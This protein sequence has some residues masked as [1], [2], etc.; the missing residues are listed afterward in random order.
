[1]IAAPSLPQRSNNRHFTQQLQ[2][3]VVI[4]VPTYCKERCNAVCELKS[5]V[6][7]KG[8]VE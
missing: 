5:N 3:R 8:N 4:Q 1:M 2:G 7:G 6:K